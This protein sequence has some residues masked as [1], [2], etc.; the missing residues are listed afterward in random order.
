MNLLDLARKIWIYLATRVH[1]QQIQTREKEQ[2]MQQTADAMVERKLL[3][4]V[5][6]DIINWQ[7]LSFS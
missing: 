7:Y 1:P 4:Q 2:L 3:F 5:A 6:K